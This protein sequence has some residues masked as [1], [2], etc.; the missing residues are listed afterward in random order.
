[1][2]SKVVC[3]AIAF[4]CLQ[5]ATYSWARAPVVPDEETMKQVEKEISR[6]VREKEF[7]ADDNLSLYRCYGKIYINSNGEEHVQSLKAELQSLSLKTERVKTNKEDDRSYMIVSM[8]SHNK[9]ELK[10]VIADISSDKEKG[11]MTFNML[12]ETEDFFFKHL[13]CATIQLSMLP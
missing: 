9:Q 8:M 7:N 4:I 6:M 3:L 11:A 1:M 13:G 5:Y 12:Q 2:N 10:N